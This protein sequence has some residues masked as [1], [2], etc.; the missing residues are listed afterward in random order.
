[1]INKKKIINNNTNNF[2]KKLR[3]NSRINIDNSKLNI[4][5]DIN[6]S[7]DSEY[8]SDKYNI[9]C[10]ENTDKMSLNQKRKEIEL[11]ILNDKEIKSLEIN[12]KEKEKPKNKIK[13]RKRKRINYKL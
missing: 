8:D 4:D 5:I 11:P 12:H 13:L 6:T 7:S 10:L 2:R 3:S 9:I 1:M